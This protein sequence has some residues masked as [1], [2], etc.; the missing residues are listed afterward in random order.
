MPTTTD[1]DPVQIEFV[2]HHEPL[3]ESGLYEITVQQVVNTQ[4]TGQK[5]IDAHFT[6]ATKQFSVYGPQFTLAPD[7]IY[8][9]FPPPGSLGDH[10]NVLPHVI[11]NRSTLPWE[12]RADNSINDVHPWLALL[13]FADGEVPPATLVQAS[14]LGVALKPGTQNPNDKIS[15]IDVPRALL[16]AIVPSLEELKLLA[17]VRQGR[18]AA[19]NVA[20]DELSVVIGNRLPQKGGTSIA[21]LVSVEDLYAKGAFDFAS[22]TGATIRLVS[23]KSWSFA[24]ENPKQ[25]FKGLLTHLNC[26]SLRLPHND[27]ETAETYLQLGYVP[28]PHF[29]RAGDRTVSWYHS[30]LATGPN[31]DESPL[32]ATAADQLVRFSRANG[33][34]DV[35]YAAAWELGRL[36]VLQSKQTSVSL[37]QWK[38]MV[39]Q[40]ANRVQQRLNAAHLPDQRSTADIPFPDD[41]GSWFHRLSLLQGVPFNY[42]VPDEEML[43]TESIRFLWLDRFWIDCLLDGAFSVG[44][45][46]GGD[47]DADRQ[48]LHCPYPPQVSDLTLANMPATNSYPNVSGFILRSEVVAGWPSLLADAYDQPQGGN[49]LNLLRLERISKDVLIALFEGEMKRVEI[50]QKPEALHFGVD[51]REEGGF[52]KTV[53]NDAGDPVKDQSGNFVSIDLGETSGLWKQF[54]QRVFDINALADQLHTDSKAAGEFTSAQFALQMIEGVEKVNFQINA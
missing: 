2:A 31:T 15:V 9:V 38:R 25:D 51:P 10:A 49:Q 36:L 17:H 44:R 22:Q 37:Y 42:L 35:S 7:E 24:C 4:A 54:S 45:V 12:R 1:T 11:L 16:E 41:A 29:M 46:T 53:R 27:S 14:E 3:L 18:D 52:Y 39:A 32:P 40:Q 23:L 26:G 47:E 43:P 13:V 6:T 33:M 21:H 50:H 48:S 5:H 34:F 20:G 28:L 19:G 30:P 8:S